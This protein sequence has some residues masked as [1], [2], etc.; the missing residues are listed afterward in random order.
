MEEIIKIDENTVLIRTVTEEKITLSELEKEIETFK[1]ANAE[2]DKLMIWRD[3]L[4]ED[5]KETVLVPPRIDTDEMEAKL[6]YYKS[7]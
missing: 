4:A 6:D 5:K 1:T 2:V 7:L 3:T